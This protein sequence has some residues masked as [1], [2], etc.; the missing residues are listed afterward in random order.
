MENN[1]SKIGSYIAYGVGQAPDTV[2]YCMFYTYFVYFITDVVGLTPMMAGA[3]SLIAI[4]WDGLSCPVIGV[5]NDRSKNPKGRRRSWMLKAIPLEFLAVIL[6]FQPFEISSQWLACG[7]YLIITIGLW[8]TYNCYVIP[9]AGLGAD[10]TEDANGRMI[11]RMSNMIFGGVYMLLCT[12]GPQVVADWAT[13]NGMSERTAWGISGFIF[14]TMALIIGFICVRAT[15]GCENL[16]AEPADDQINVFVLVKESLSSKP[17]RKVCLATFF[18]FVGTI[19][20]GAGQVYLVEYNCGLDYDGEAFFWVM[21]SV[22]YTLWVPIITWMANK[23]GRKLTL[24]IT[25]G[26]SII[27][28]IIY[29]IVGM[30]SLADSL[31]YITIF[32]FGNAYFYT[33]YYAW[34]YDCAEL[35]SYKTGMRRESSFISVLSFAQKLGGAIGT[36]SIGF[37]LTIVGYDAAA[38][39]QTQG[40]LTGILFINTIMLAIACALA[41]VFMAKYPI[42]EKVVDAI[43]K[44]NEDKLAGRPVDESEFKHLL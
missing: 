38:E 34:A 32:N 33:V 19:C 5:L 15:R 42:S 2:P 16:E 8:T 22:T 1:K 26:V 31:I 17:F 9:Y 36:Y 21:Y 7:F 13:T 4:I 3:I 23:W 27:L 10:I 14:S 20:V 29:F 25:Q 18:Y 11:V 24:M 12:S 41:M 28:S 40:A 39:V 37:I 35:D 43:A 44:A 30:D 6:L